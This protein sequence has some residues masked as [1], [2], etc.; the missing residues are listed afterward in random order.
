M[1]FSPQKTVGFLIGVALV[2]GLILLLFLTFGGNKETLVIPLDS[3][4]SST[5]AINE[6]ISEV[7]QPEAQPA[8]FGIVEDEE[9]NPI[10][11]AIVQAMK[12]TAS[13]YDPEVFTCTGDDGAYSLSG[14]G[15]GDRCR[16]IASA[17][18]FFPTDSGEFLFDSSPK[19]FNFVLKKWP[20]L[21]ATDLPPG[22]LEIILSKA[23]ASIEKIRN[24][25]IVFVRY[26]AI[27]KRLS[28]RGYKAS[29]RSHTDFLRE[30]GY[31]EEEIEEKM[32][33]R[34]AR[35]Q[36]ALT[37]E[38]F[39]E[40]VGEAEYCFEGEKA[41]GTYLLSIEGVPFKTY[42]NYAYDNKNILVM[43]T[44]RDGRTQAEIRSGTIPIL[45]NVDSPFRA[46][47]KT[48]PALQKRD[49]W[50][51]ALVA[52][53]TNGERIYNLTGATRDYRWSMQILPEKGHFI[54]GYNY[55]FGPGNA[56]TAFFE[57][58]K[59]DSEAGL[60][61]PTKLTEIIESDGM[62]RHRT[63]HKILEVEFNKD[64]DD[65]IFKP[66]FEEGTRITDYRFSP[67]RQ[68]T[69]QHPDYAD[70]YLA[71]LDEEARLLEEEKKDRR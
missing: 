31:S 2:L 63:V 47:L 68:L 67:P 62:I 59:W 26:S 33:E 10:A 18:G 34:I 21:P 11:G 35:W 27:N 42:A 43:T 28:E 30:R 55:T 15:L 49:Q 3:P 69:F 25:R 71:Q 6:E 54:R 70:E 66:V 17:W 48:I 23:L 24:G 65:G 44:L 20:S 37:A 45:V 61:Y 51:A 46:L 4:Q 56:I 32:S 53:G 52:T 9:R 8:I 14:I 60:Y 36:E 29:I 13:V 41:Y 39:D 22:E 7:G 64:Y 16:L 1:N 58:I 57:D 12:A 50:N 40:D 5:S 38:G 19:E